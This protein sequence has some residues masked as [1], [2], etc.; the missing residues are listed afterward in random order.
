MEIKTFYAPGISHFSYAILGQKGIAIIDPKRII[1]DYLSLQR[2]TSLPITH[3][4]L[5][6]THADFI[7]G[8]VLLKEATGAEIIFPYEAEEGERLDL[9]DVFLKVMKTPGHTPDHV[10]YLLYE[11]SSGGEIPFAVFTGDSL[12]AGDVGRPDLFGEEI[13]EELTEH[14]F[15]TTGKYQK[16]PDHV[17]VYPAHGAGSF[18]GKR[19]S[20]RCPT[21]IGYE[22][23]HNW[24]LK[25]T[26]Y[27][28]FKKHL[29]EGMPLPPPYYFTT[30]RRNS[31][32][33][34]LERPLETLSELPLFS[35]EEYLVIDLRD[36]ACFAAFHL[37]GALNIAADIHFAT[38]A[39]F[40]LDPKDPL[41]LVG[42]RE[43]IPYAYE[44]LFMMGFD[45]VAGTVS[46]AIEKW[47][48]RALP[49]N[50]FRLLSPKEAYELRRAG[51]AII[52]DVRTE[53]EF[54]ESHIPEALHLP[55]VSLKDHLANLPEDK[56]LIFQC[57]HGCRGSL[58]ASLA[59]RA[60][61]KNVANLAGGILAWKASNLPLAGD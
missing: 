26:N 42:E 61:L 55:L 2:E 41:I 44:T 24:A 57:G 45:G 13:R 21:T 56:L 22:K 60:G 5:T 25:C 38:G 58:A 12:F 34:G 3:I 23:I 18:C 53:A 7:S 8:H 15:E 29:L 10:S 46:N 36:Q 20:Q 48:V 1:R 43:K 9:G 16:L 33:E 27:E 39:G 40:T 28:E 47:R 4:L 50:S 14:L 51:E 54:A 59:L 31:Q 49:H 11:K 6:H 19:L 32:E 30:S 35:L 37:P 17:L 52:V